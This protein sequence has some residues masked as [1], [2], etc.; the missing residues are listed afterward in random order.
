MI[1]RMDDKFIVLVDGL[2]VARYTARSCSTR[3][4]RETA[5]TVLAD[6][7]WQHIVPRFSMCFFR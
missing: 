5:V 2:P 1:W 4:Q 6:D 3:L 7:W